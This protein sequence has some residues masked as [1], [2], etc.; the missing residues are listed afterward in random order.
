MPWRSAAPEVATTHP[1][2]GQPA[3]DGGPAPAGARVRGHADRLVD[4]D[5]VVVLV[6]DAP[7]PRPTRPH[8]RRG[9]AGRAGSPRATSRRAPG[10]TSPAPTRRARRRPRHQVGGLGSGRG[11]TAGSGRRRPARPPGRRA[12]AASGGQASAGS[13]GGSARRAGRAGQLL[14]GAATLAGAVPA[15]P[16]RV[17]RTTR[18]PAQT[19]AVSARLKIGQ[20]GN[21]RK[22]T[23]C[24][25]ATPGARNSR[26][27]RFP[28]RAAEQQAEGHGPDPAT[29]A[30]ARPGP[31]RRRPRRRSASGPR[32][33]RS[34][35][36]R[37]R[38]RCG[39]GRSAGPD[40]GSRSAAPR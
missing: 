14:G 15:H 24:P 7:A 40:R 33:S 5:Q 3:Q 22:S 19:I 10:R 11:R 8:R 4:D 26:S 16:R 35:W 2:R 21:S 27:A 6:D 13:S 1:G 28:Q 17:S 36:R 20:C 9:A 32:S 30:G 12:P 31:R 23:T 25:R 38:R 37:P 18:T 39:S 34:P 29:A